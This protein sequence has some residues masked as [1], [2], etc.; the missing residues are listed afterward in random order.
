MYFT[1]QLNHLRTIFLA[2]DI[3]DNLIWPIA[4][5]TILGLGG[6]IWKRISSRKKKRFVPVIRLKISKEGRLGP[7]KDSQFFKKML[8]AVKIFEDQNKNGIKVKLVPNYTTWGMDMY[9][10]KADKLKLNKKAKELEKKIEILLKIDNLSSYHPNIELKTAF[11][12]IIAGKPHWNK[13]NEYLTSGKSL[14]ILRVAKPSINFYID[15][16]KKHWEQVKKKSRMDSNE[17]ESG[18]Y[19]DRMIFATIFRAHQEI[20]C[21]EVIPSLVQ[22]IYEIHTYHGFDLKTPGWSQLGLYYVQNH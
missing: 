15:I 6:V 13:S 16:S 18:L 17:I 10:K 4:V 12:A 3:W 22:K 8:L 5:A 11:D 2:T 21:T 9:S 1:E 20:Y 14:E 7:L 19:M